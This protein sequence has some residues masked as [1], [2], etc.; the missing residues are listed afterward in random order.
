MAACYGADSVGGKPFKLVGKL[1]VMGQSLGPDT[2]AF[3]FR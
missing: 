1:S 2:I 3:D